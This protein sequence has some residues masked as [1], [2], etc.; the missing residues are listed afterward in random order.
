MRIRSMVL[1]VL[2]VC[3]LGGCS[4]RM[5]DL[6]IISSKNVALNP[7]PI[8][9]S[10]EGKDCVYRLLG[11]IPLGSWIPNVEEAMDDALASVPDGN[12]LTDVA[13]YSDFFT[14]IIVSQQCLR[15]KGDIG[16]LE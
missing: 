6:Q 9:R 15:V 14:A 1:A 5:G 7:D 13:I 12:I 4:L 11:L 16:R 2:T 10:V 3:L 8:R